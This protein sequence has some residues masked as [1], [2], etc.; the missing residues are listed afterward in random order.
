MRDTL[1]RLRDWLLSFAPAIL[2]TGAVFGVALYFIQPAPPRSITM[3]TGAHDGAYEEFG[4]RYRDILARDGITVNLLPS[5]G[6]VENL[7]RLKTREDVDVGF[8]QGGIATVQGAESLRSLG[9]LYYEPLWLFLRRGAHVRKLADLAGKRVAIGVEG[10]GTRILALELLALNALSPVA[11]TLSDAGGREAADALMKNQLDAIFVIAA[12]ESPLVQDLMH[13]RSVR[14]HHFVQTEAYSRRYP[15][16]SAVVLPEGVMDFARDIPARD[17]TLL[18]PTASL[19]VK[20]HLHPAIAY[21]LLQA[22]REIHGDAGM[23]HRPYEFPNARQNDVPLSK[24]ATRFYESGPRFFYRYL[25]FWLATLVDRLVVVL[26]PTLAV[27]VPLARIAP[28]LYSWRVGSR[29][30]RWYGQLKYLEHDVRSHERP[31]KPE[32]VAGF[33]KRLGEIE[34]RVNDVPTPLAFSDRFYTLRQHIELVRS[35]I[36]RDEGKSG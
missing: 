19:V 9:S 17:V 16:L 21:L 11:M 26:V 22:A 33:T 14:L 24:E 7:D 10:S 27:L 23:L 29:I 32:E 12:P 18:A 6:A 20:E 8:V 35:Q 2:I 15:F 28:S 31:L 30:Y 36:L 13:A 25:P 3:T 5:A 34:R 1:I 4:Q